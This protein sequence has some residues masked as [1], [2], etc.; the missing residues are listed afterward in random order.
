MRL[1]S[2]RSER[3]QVL[4]CRAFMQAASLSRMLA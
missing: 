4:D 1:A 3:T 2:E